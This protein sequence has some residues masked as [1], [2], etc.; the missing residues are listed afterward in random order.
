[1]RNLNSIIDYSRKFLKKEYNLELTHDIII[2]GRLTST[3]GQVV[4]HHDYSDVVS[5]QLAK[6]VV[7]HAH[8]LVLIDTIKHELIHY[9]LWKLGKPFSDADEY[10]QN[11]LIKHGADGSCDVYNVGISYGF[12]C[13]KCKA[14]YENNR[15]GNLYCHCDHSF[16]SPMKITCE[17]F[18]DG[19]TKQVKKKFK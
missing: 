14:K 12:E 7:E 3:Y 5:I 10:F 13:K 6:R 16:T 1:M 17:Y 11:E 9:A 15:K 19:V 2:N 8:D 4:Y 18:S